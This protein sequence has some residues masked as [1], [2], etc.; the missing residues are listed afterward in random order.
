MSQPPSL[1][2]CSAAVYHCLI[3]KAETEQDNRQMRLRYHVQVGSGLI[4]KR[5]VADWIIMDKHLFQ[6]RSGGRKLAA[7]KPVSTGC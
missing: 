3:R 7:N 5:V 4:R 6:V 1:G 2:D